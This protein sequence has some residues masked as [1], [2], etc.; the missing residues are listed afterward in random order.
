MKVLL[1][2]PRGFCAG[3]GRA[4]SIVERSLEKYGK[5]VYV[6]HEIVHNKFVV[7]GLKEKGAV[8]IEEL[9]E[10]PEGAVVIFSAH[11][12]P[13]AVAQEAGR[14]ELVSVDATCP[15]VKKV[16]S[17][18][19]SHDKQGVEVVL[20]GHKGH[21]EVEGTMG[22][23]APGKVA[24]VASVEDVHVLEGVN[25]DNLA[26]T[27]QTTLS[28]D[29]TKD[30]IVALRE[31]FPHIKGPEQG[32]LCYATTNRQRAVREMINLVDLFLVIGSKNSSNS[33]RLREIGTEEG[34]ESYLI[35]GPQDIFQ[36][37]FEGVETVG[38]SSGA[39]A[40]ESLVQEVVQWI[41]ANY[42]GAESENH[43]LLEENVHF[44]LPKE[45]RGD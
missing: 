16:H 22:Q 27:T 5:P 43:I 19:L 20:I 6:R 7:E 36:E 9:H 12:V 33:N 34:I 1:A 23:L 15:L 38:I 42:P 44:P 37:W 25:P 13:Q 45:L 40:P 29:E 24:L 21:P 11:G 26:Y 3:V 35:D 31:R 4:I 10:V 8:F 28:M 14:R 32:D 2:S 17:S 39:S 30:V 41:K 18:V